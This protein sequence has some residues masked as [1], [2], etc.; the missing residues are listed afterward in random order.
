[1][2]AFKVKIT[3]SILLEINPKGYKVG[4]CRLLRGDKEVLKGDYSKIFLYEKLYPY[5]KGEGD[6]LVGMEELDLTGFSEDVIEVYR[7]LKERVPFGE[8]I[9]YSELGKLV[10]KHPRFIGYCMKINRFPIIVPCHRVVSKKDLGGFAYGK[11]M[12]EL[13]LSFEGKL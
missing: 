6:V 7:T 2:S 5:L 9:T 8:R 13:L 4:F 10:G 11:E 1:M 3:Q 12:K